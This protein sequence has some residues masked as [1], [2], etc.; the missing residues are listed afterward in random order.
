MTA[1][2]GRQPHHLVGVDVVEA[3]FHAGVQVVEGRVADT[4]V[5]VVLLLANLA[6]VG[7]EQRDENLLYDVFGFVGRADDAFRIERRQPEMLAE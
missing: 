1:F 7:V 3:V 6:E 2:F 4:A 5:E